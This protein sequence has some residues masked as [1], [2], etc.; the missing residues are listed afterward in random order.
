MYGKSLVQCQGMNKTFLLILA[1]L[2]VESVERNCFSVLA[3]IS[4][5]LN[6]NIKVVQF[7]LLVNKYLNTVFFII[8]SGCSKF[9]YTVPAKQAF[10]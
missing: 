6:Y 5:Y 2:K 10:E 4:R 1:F 8:F 9:Y 3:N 7:P